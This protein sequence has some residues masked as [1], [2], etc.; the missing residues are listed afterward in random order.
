MRRVVLLAAVLLVDLPFAT[1]FVQGSDRV[2]KANLKKHPFVIGSLRL[3]VSIFRPNLRDIPTFVRTPGQIEV[4]IENGSDRG[5]EYAPSKLSLVGSDDQQ[6][7]LR[8][9]MQQGIVNPDDDRLE[10]LQA[11]T[12]APGAKIKEFYELTGPVRLPARLYYGDQ[13]LAVIT[14]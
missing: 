2:R 5:V 4:R 1:A 9:R 6:V 11:K 3:T 13:E 8:G 7:N 12:L 10:P 14:D